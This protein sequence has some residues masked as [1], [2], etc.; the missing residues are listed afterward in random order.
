[1]LQDEREKRIQRFCRKTLREE[2]TQPTIPW[3]PGGLSGSK[4]AGAWAAHYPPSIAEVKNKHNCTSSLPYNLQCKV[5]LEVLNVN[6]RVKEFPLYAPQRFITKFPE[7]C[8][9]TIFSIRNSVTTQNLL[10]QRSIS[11]LF[12]H[13]RG[14]GSSVSI[15]T[16]YGLDGP[17]IE[18]RWGWD[19]P[20]LSR[21]ALGPS[22]PPV[23]WV[24]G[25]SRG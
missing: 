23:Q 21:P 19:F 7:A 1:M 4:A 16:G 12:S 6:H 2:T 20:Y 9:W 14:P 24:L 3:V 10:S 15:V 25:L 5:L 8:H 17:G 18:S 13:L 22:Q 11:I